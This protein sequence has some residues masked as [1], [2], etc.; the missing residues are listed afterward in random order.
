MP[1]SLSESVSAWSSD[2]RR[3]RRFSRAA[4]EHLTSLS[5][6]SAKRNRHGHILSIHFRDQDGGS[7]LRATASLGQ[8]Y[9]FKT[10]VGEACAVV[11]DHKSLVGVERDDFQRVLLAS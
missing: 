9:S 1:A 8:R 4:A 7:A 5:K 2:G 11:W 6:V 10:R 3:L